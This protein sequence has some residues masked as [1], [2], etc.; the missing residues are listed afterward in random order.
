MQL[1]ADLHIHSHYSRATSKDLTPE[2]LD[3]WARVKGIDVVGTGDFTHPAWTAELQEKFAPAEE[4]LFA[5]RP[6]FQLSDRQPDPGGEVRFMLTAEISCIYKYDG[7]VR[8]VHHVVCAPDFATVDRIQK[9]LGRIGNITSDGRPILG[10]DSRDL[11]EIV[12]EASPE[13]FFIPAH[14]WTPWFST[15]GSKSGFDSIEECFRDLAPHIHAVET[16]LSSDP[17][18]NWMC[19]SLDR[20]TLVSNSDAHSPEKLGR[21]ANRLETERSYPAIIAALQHGEQAGFRGTIEFFPQEGKY[22]FDGHRKCGIRWDPVETIRHNGICPQCNRPITQGVLSRVA[23]LADRDRIEARPARSEFASLVP[24]K[25]LLSELLGV[26]P[27][28]KRVKQAYDTLVSKGGSELSILSTVDLQRCEQIGGAPFAEAVRRMRARQVVVDEGFDGEYGR[29]RVFAAGEAPSEREQD[30]LFADVA[31]VAAPSALA[32]VE[33]DLAALQSI[34]RA[35]ATAAD[36]QHSA[37]DAAQSN[38]ASPNAAEP[39]A[40]QASTVGQNDTREPQPNAAQPGAAQPVDGAAADLI[41]ELNP[42]QREAVVRV[43]GPSLILA[44]P[45]TG[46]TKTLTTRIA[47][48]IRKH[49]VAP[50]SILAL[51]F[52]NK[53]AQEMQQR[54]DSLLGDTPADHGPAERPLIATFHAFGLAL[55]RELAPQTGRDA[56]FSIVGHPE[57]LALIHELLPDGADRS[58]RERTKLIDRIATAKQQL[59]T[60]QTLEREDPAFAQLFDRYERSLQEINAFDLDDL[61]RIPLQLINADAQLQQRYRDRFAWIL[62]DEYQDVNELQ[63]RLLRTLAPDHSA[64]LCVIGDPNQ[65]IY[66]FRGAMV[67]Y[68]RAFEADYPNAT[69]HRLATSYRCPDRILS[70][71]AQVLDAAAGERTQGIDAGVNTRIVATQTDRSEAEFVARTIEQL[72]GGLQFF[73]IDSAVTAGN[74]AEGIASLAD[75]AILCRTRRQMPAIA[76]ALLDH[77]IPYQRIE[78]GPLFPSGAPRLLIDLAKYWRNPRSRVAELKLQADGITPDVAALPQQLGTD[79]RGAAVPQVLQALQRIH[80]IDESY[81]E[82][83]QLPELLRIAGD[84]GTD[85]DAFL[86]SIDLGSGVDRYRRDSEQ[87]SLMTLHAA[88]GLEFGAVFVVGCEDGLIP[89]TLNRKTTDSAEERRLLYVGMTRAKRYLYLTHAGRRTLFGREHNNARSPFLDDL[90]QELLDRLEPGDHRKP[91]AKR[92]QLDLFDRP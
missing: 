40:T 16:G 7:K 85:H 1:I 23:Q 90:E 26:G 15:L 77:H 69:V 68:I 64:N 63:Y 45:G 70:A 12:L 83:A 55:L 10:L 50:G 30:L 25:E 60:L 29:V 5:L 74:A 48:L 28:S 71:S 13:A 89:Y 88:K 2:H 72:L 33:F 53:A 6:E 47:Y 73:S 37:S 65:A 17:P 58:Q 42:M 34:K 87:V 31:K 36:G 91:E 52:T 22:H 49:K 76:K 59:A 82:A 18:M 24:L 3:Y 9:E 80:G 86:R 92:S 11:L 21:E 79:P 44:G 39:G 75:V 14:I 46:K 56:Q 54:V 51:T 35:A 81:A 61:I 20:F 43:D 19:S 32:M 67:G 41:H 8:K 66:G 78:S 84:F 62:V 38:A 27:A 4:G 57:R